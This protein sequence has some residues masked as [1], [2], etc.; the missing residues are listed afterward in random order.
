MITYAMSSAPKRPPVAMVWRSP[1][2]AACDSPATRGRLPPPDRSTE[3]L[4]QYCVARGQCRNSPVLP[5]LAIQHGDSAPFSLHLTREAVQSRHVADLV[6]R[7]RKRRN[8]V[9]AGFGDKGGGNTVE[10]IAGHFSHR[11]CRIG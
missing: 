11:G 6:K 8:A 9:A 1:A 10:V 5:E 3:R 4:R 2:G 7:G